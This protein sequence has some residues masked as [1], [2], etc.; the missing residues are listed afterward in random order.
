ME[1]Q[2]ARHSHQGVKMKLSDAS[3]RQIE[4]AH[5][6]RSTWLA[7]NAGSGKTRVL[8]DR[9]ARLLLD[10]VMP[11][12]ILCLTYTKAAASE[13]QNRLFKRLGRWT[14]LDDVTL[15]EELA[16]LGVER[17]LGPDDIDRARTLFARAVEAPGGLKIQTIHSFCAAILR[18]FPLEAGVNPQ[19]VEID[20]RAQN[21]LLD[22][23]VE[24]IA[25][26]QGQ[27]SFD[28]IAEHFTGPDLQKFLHAILN[29][30]HHFDSHPGADGIWKALGLP[31]GYDDASLAQ[32]CFLPDDFE[33]IE[34][35][36]ALLMTKDENSNDFKAGLRLQ[37]IPG[38]ALTTADLPTLESVFLNK[39]GKAPGLAKIGSF[40]TKATR[41]ELPGMAQV[42]ALMLRVEAGRQSRLSLNVARRSLALYD[43]AAEFLGTYRARKQAR[44]F[45]DFNDLIMRTRHLL[46]DERV[47][48][49]V[50]FRL[51]GGID[52]ILV[53]EA[54]DT[55][56]AQWDVIRLLA[57]EFTSGEGARADVPRTIFVV[58]D[59]KQSIYSFQGADPD[60]FDRMRDQFSQKLHEIDQPFQSTT[61]DYSFRS[62]SAILG[63]V[64]QVFANRSG[65][66]SGSAHLAFKADLPGRVDVWPVFQAPD[67]TEPHH[68]T[69]PVDEVSTDHQDKQ[70]AD[71][72]AGH[73]CDLIETETLTQLD[74]TGA[75]FQRKITAGDFLIL[76]QGRQKLLFREIHRA[77]K[78]AG[79]PIAGADRLKVAAELA[80]RDIRSLLAFLALPEDNL[81]LAEA[82]KSPLFGWSEQELFDLAQ[83]RD[84]PF[85]WRSL[86]NREEEFPNTVQRLT[87]L[88]D[89][90]D[91]KRPFELIEHILTTR[92]GRSALLGQLGPEAAEGIDALVS[93][94]LAYE[95]SNIPNL[96]GFLVWLDADDLEIKRQM[97]S[98]G[99]KIRVMTVHGA[100]GLE[101]PIV[102]LPD[103][104]PRKAPKLPEVVPH[105]TIAVWSPNKDLIPA[106]LQSSLK[107][108]QRQQE[109]ERDRLLYVAMTRAESWLIVMGSGDIKEGKECWHNA[110]QDAISALG[111]APLNTVAG[112]GLR[113]EPMQWSTGPQSDPVQPQIMKQSV[114]SWAIPYTKPAQAPA[115]PRSPSD[116]GGDKVLPGGAPQDAENAK[117]LGTA[118]HRL[119]EVLP[120]APQDQWGHIAQRLVEA[121][122]QA[123]AFQ[124]A[125][126]VLQQPQLAYIFAPESL[127]EVDISAHLPE[128]N[129][130]PIQGSIDRLLI[131][132]TRVLAVDFKSNQIVPSEVAQV[133]SGLL[134]QMGA[135]AAALSQI[136]PHHD[137]ETAILWTK[138]LELMPLPPDLVISSLANTSPA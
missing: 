90:A 125:R 103:T 14:M 43:F 48:T 44:G 126:A 95:R 93:Q 30:D 46:S 122:I 87:E 36:K 27:S 68:W 124:E 131:S 10:G 108:K 115:A 133:P 39:T 38:P 4:A 97:D 2:P 121:D 84:S 47:A 56:P 51:D 110:I 76:V 114:P 3:L 12:N 32:E 26:G 66:G 100:K 67:K 132:P 73:I 70:L 104:A 92:G 24:A 1:H 75:A 34:E 105:N 74:D 11:Q 130:D 106:A 119:L 111:A 42:E 29:L 19:F 61:L 33:H 59:K 57:Q 118:V 128:L 129:G 82:L 25:D 7:A 31:A 17:D 135:Y 18:R 78:E 65:L 109:E 49:W 50:L 9:V 107:D 117:R 120:N 72:L 55:S 96:T 81:S 83:R 116:L 16:A 41:A 58:G 80:V 63:V 35:L 53:D 8:T 136:Y 99:D 23:V 37:A 15:L 79:L 40:P 137:I 112:L 69:D 13:M 6:G 138:T 91:F 45:L 60:G 71:A 88:R 86:Q 98:V 5:P 134:R 21:L 113:Y 127:A 102:I 89:L 77:C 123:A 22:E 52:H 54:Q 62:S 94:S 28:G 85:L 20:E 101:A 64:D